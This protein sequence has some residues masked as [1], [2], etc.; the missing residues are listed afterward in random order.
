MTDAHVKVANELRGREITVNAVAP[1]PVSTE[2]FLKGK[3]EAQ[4]EQFRRLAPLERLGRPEDIAYVGSFLAGPGGCWVN[5][6]VVPANG[7]QARRGRAGA[8]E[9]LPSGVSARVLPAGRRQAG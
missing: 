4:I 7:G 9:H 1:G 8:A 5:A 2:L 6:Q 3:T